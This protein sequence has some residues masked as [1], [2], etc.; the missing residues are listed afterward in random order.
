MLV[1]AQ[2]NGYNFSAGDSFG[3]NNPV[4]SI[5]WFDAVKWCNAR[6]EMLG[7]IPAYYIDIDNKKTYRFGTE[8]P[9][10]VEWNG[11]YR[12]PTEAEWE[13]AARGESKIKNIPG[14]AIPSRRMMRI[15]MTLET[16]EP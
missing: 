16:I 8:P 5:N 3:A 4:H 15:I 13:K 1:W 9:L 2:N 11:G 14:V 7:L 12:L 6:S 10:G